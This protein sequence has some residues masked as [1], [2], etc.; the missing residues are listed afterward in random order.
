MVYSSQSFTSISMFGASASFCLIAPPTPT[1]FGVFAFQHRRSPFITG[2]CTPSIMCLYNSSL[3]ILA[4][5][6]KVFACFHQEHK[7][8]PVVQL[9]HSLCSELH[10]GKLLLLALIVSLQYL[11]E[12]RVLLHNLRVPSCN[13][14]SPDFSIFLAYV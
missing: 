3:S 9:L 6:G 10:L 11:I 5:I 8:L 4:C 7:R 13:L 14:C 12:S 1:P 2:V